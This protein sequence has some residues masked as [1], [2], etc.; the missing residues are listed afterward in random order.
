SSRWFV[1]LIQAS[2]DFAVGVSIV[3]DE[4][5]LLVSSLLVKIHCCVGIVCGKI[6]CWCRSWD[7]AINVAVASG[8]EA[9]QVAEL[10]I[11]ASG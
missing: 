10:V 5:S 6:R 8:S 11:G 4:L 2:L 3:G 9:L 7:F 1:P